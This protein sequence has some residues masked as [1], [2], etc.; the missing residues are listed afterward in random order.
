[1]R[2]LLAI[3]AMLAPLAVQ[4]QDNTDGWELRAGLSRVTASVCSTEGGCFGV[5]CTAA[6]GWRPLWIVETGSDAAADP[7]VGIRLDGA[8]YALTNL[9]DAGAGTFSGAVRSQDADLLDALQSGESVIVDPG[10]DFPLIDLTLRGSRWA[11]EQTL[12]L[13][14]AGGPE[15][16]S[17]EDEAEG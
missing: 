10:R 14:E 12:A 9:S 15:I 7:I 8:R 6:G 2:Y 11:L 1:M 4:A 5:T 3:G 16:F 13:C 17:P